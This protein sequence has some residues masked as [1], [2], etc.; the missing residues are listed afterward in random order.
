MIVVLFEV[1]PLIDR[2]QHYL[3]HAAALYRHVQAIDGFVS[4]ERFQ[5]LADPARLLSLSTWRDEAAL[6]TWRALPV[7][8]AV[9]TRAREQIFAD[10]RLRVA[11]VRRDYGMQR[12]EQAP[13]D[14]RRAHG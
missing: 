1:Q 14:S 8:R 10:Y 4:I 7:H 3:D 2:R 9:Q 12:R 11:E 6:A 13:G 5:S